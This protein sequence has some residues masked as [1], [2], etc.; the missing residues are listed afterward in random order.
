MFRGISDTTSF[1]GGTWDYN[2][3]AKRQLSVVAPGAEAFSGFLADGFPQRYAHIRCTEAN[4]FATIIA[5]ATDG[6]ALGDSR[7]IQ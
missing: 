4:G 3:T 7:R 2:N 6:K 1:Q 5:V